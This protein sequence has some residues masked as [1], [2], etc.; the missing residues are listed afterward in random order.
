MDTAPPFAK[1]R[2]TGGRSLVAFAAVYAALFSGYGLESPFLPSFF[3]ERGLSPV[4]IGTVLSCGTAVRLLSGPA[5]GFAA[6]RFDATKLLLAVAAIASGLFGLGYLAG[7]SFWPI[8]LVG[9]VHSAVIAP[10]NPLADTLAL[11][12][13]ERGELASYGWVR[14]IGSAAFIVGTLVSGQLVAAFGLPSI[15]VSSSLLFLIL[16]GVTLRLPPSTGRRAEGWSF[17]NLWGLAAIPVFRRLLVVA[18]LI[19]GSHAM[20]DTFAVIH[21]RA[22]GIRPGAVSFLWSEAVVAEVVTFFLLGPRLIES[23][24]AAR[25]AALAAGAGVLRWSLFATSSSLVILTGGQL[26]HG[27]T[28]ALLHLACMRLIVGC[29]PAHLLASAQ[30]LYGT[31]SIGLVSAVM[32]LLSGSVYQHF[33]AQGF[34][35]MALLCLAALPVAWGLHLRRDAP[36]FNP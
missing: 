2:A 28:F 33:G 14:G 30:S 6:D 15:L 1:A 25:C 35:L 20:S 21:W 9:L 29:V 31:L 19:M 17:S 3:A 10:L 7:Y 13:S 5:I 24:G 34:W 12:A 23:W 4:A 8:L 11:A 26:L 36:P 27:L 32:T 18:G 16:A 22:A